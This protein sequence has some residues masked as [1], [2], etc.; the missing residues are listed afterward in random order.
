MRLAIMPA[1]E[2]DFMTVLIHRCSLLRSILICTATGSM[3]SHSPRCVLLETNVKF[4]MY[5]LR[6]GATPPSAPALSEGH[7][8]LDSLRPTGCAIS[9]RRTLGMSFVLRKF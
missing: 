9:V 6:V 7:T 4:V 1:V 8:G 2:T 5:K 3:H